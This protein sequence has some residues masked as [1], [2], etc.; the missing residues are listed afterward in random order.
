MRDDELLMTSLTKSRFAVL[1]V[2]DDDSEGELQGVSDE[3]RRKFDDSKNARK[4]KKK[5]KKKKRSRQKSNE[6]VEL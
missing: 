4:T 2:S 5:C 6:V 3:A 1:E